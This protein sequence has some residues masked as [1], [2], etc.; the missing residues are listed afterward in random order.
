MPDNGKQ[1]G[2]HH[3]VTRNAKGGS[4][5]NQAADPAGQRSLEKIAREG[6]QPAFKPHDTQHVAGARVFAAAVADIHALCA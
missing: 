4:R 1:P 5:Q 3:P 2:Q 6:D